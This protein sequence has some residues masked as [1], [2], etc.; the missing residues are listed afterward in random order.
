MLQTT[1]KSILKPIVSVL[2][3]AYNVEK[4]IAI[5]IESIL[6]QS[7]TNFEFIILDDGSSDS[8]ARIIDS[9][10]DRRIRK[11]F[12][13][14]NIGLVNA[15]NTLVTMAEGRF[16]A[17]LDADDIAMTDRLETQVQVLEADLADICGASYFSLYEEMGKKKSSRQRYSDSDIRALMV[18]TSPLCNPTVMVKAEIL[19]KYPYQIGK[20]YAEDYS[21][22]VKLALEGYRFLNLRQ[23]LIIY[24]IYAAQTSQVQQNGINSVFSQSRKEYIDS[25][26]IPLSMIPGPISIKHRITLAIPFMVILNKRIE[27]ISVAANSEIYSRYQFRSNGML[28]P[29]TRMER[30]LIAIFVSLIRF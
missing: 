1:S 19:K 27:G 20:N 12:L 3:P 14:Q 4:Y 23:K 7:F 21:L 30:W 11:V 24:R 10:A 8:T 29:F 16:I 5:A 2:M 17:F 26:G 28:T 13:P 18:I 6:N 25:L 9:Y 22:W 15:R